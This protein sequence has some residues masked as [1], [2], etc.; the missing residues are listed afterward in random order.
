MSQRMERINKQALAVLGDAI[1]DLKDPRIGFVTLTSVR[2]TPD[3]RH[4]RIAVSVLGDDE[5]RRA[6]MAGLRSARP[7]L[8][9]L[10]GHEMT[11][12]Y[13]PEL[14][15]VLDTGAEEAAHLEAIIKKIHD[16][17]GSSGEP[18]DT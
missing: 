18:T 9:S 6:T 7:H 12:K 4:A 2:I 8:R 17:D 3:L 10:L 16:E 1:R 14:D 13:L 15:F 11:L 5:E